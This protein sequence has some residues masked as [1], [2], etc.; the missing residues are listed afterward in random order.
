MRQT[1]SASSNRGTSGQE[2]GG[3]GEVECGGA[4]GDIRAHHDEGGKHV[5]DVPL[6]RLNQIEVGGIVLLIHQQLVHSNDARRDGDHGQ[7]RFPGLLLIPHIQLREQLL[8]KALHSAQCGEEE[9]L[10]D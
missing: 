3:G 7:S 8:C 5:S 2:E 1:C 6:P 10:A 9:R 4:G